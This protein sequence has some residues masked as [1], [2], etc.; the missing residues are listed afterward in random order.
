MMVR[1]LPVL[2]LEQPHGRN[3][4]GAENLMKGL[5]VHLSN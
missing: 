1:D 4:I 2:S 3:R 5:C